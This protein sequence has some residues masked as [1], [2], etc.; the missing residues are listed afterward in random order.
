MTALLVVLSFWPIRNLF[1]RRQ[2]MNASFNR[3]QLVNAYG[4]F[5]SVTRRRIEVI[6][7]G[8]LEDSPVD[9]AE[10]REYQFKGKPGDPARMPRQF[11]P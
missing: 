7:E 6:V 2:L 8:T 3:W 5:G 10:W 9:T 1:S 4:A 11:A